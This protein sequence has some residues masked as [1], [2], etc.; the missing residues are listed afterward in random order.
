VRIRILGSAAG[1][2]F[3]QWNCS[4]DN[5]RNLRAGTLRGAPRAQSSIAVSADG[6]RWCLINAGPDLRAQIL[7]FDPL[8]PRSGRRGS[9]IDAILL[10]DAEIDH[11]GGLLSLRETQAL[12]LYCSAPV[13]EWVFTSNPMFAALIQPAKLIWSP[14]H[15]RAIQPIRS[16]DDRDIGLAYQALFVH[17]KV[18]TYVRPGPLASDGATLAYRIIDVRRGSSLLYVPV[19]R[20]MDDDLLSAVPASA[21][22]L[23][24][25]SF[26]SEREL[27]SRGVGTRTASSMGHL[28]IGGSDGS[29]ARL[30]HLG[31]MRR[32][33]THVNNTNPILDECSP[34]RRALEEAGW[35]VAEDGMEFDV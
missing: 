10:T 13:F 21:C 6:T 5:C 19:V 20:E 22:L 28:P 11:V 31:P 14:V 9:A 32:I 4:C 15:D 3:P 17:G 30:H 27:E 29:L 12:R 2:G 35:E 7:S 18:P 24:D 16:S 25:G 26:W 34:E 23:F 8:A 33:Y 1:G